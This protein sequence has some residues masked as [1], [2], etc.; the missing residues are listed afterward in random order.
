MK[1]ALFLFPLVFLL[2]FDSIQLGTDYYVTAANE[3]FEE[4]GEQEY[5]RFFLQTTEGTVGGIIRHGVRYYQI[6]IPDSMFFYDW[7][8]IPYKQESDLDYIFT[9]L[10]DPRYN[11]LDRTWHLF[12]RD[13]LSVANRSYVQD[14]AWDVG[15]VVAP[16]AAVGLVCKGGKYF[17][18]SRKGGKVFMGMV[19]SSSRVKRIV[20]SSWYSGG[21]VIDEAMELA[22]YHLYKHVYIPYNSGRLPQWM[23]QIIRNRSTDDV[24]E[25]YT[26]YFQNLITHQGTRVE[27]FTLDNGKQAFK[28]FWGRG[29]NRNS[30]GCTF[31]RK[32]NGDVQLVTAFFSKNPNNIPIL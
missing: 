2:S 23:N 5:D 20:T 8:D 3:V 25:W 10:A 14:A 24:F 4:Q 31:V 30:T 12:E 29:A 22:S 15:M 7:G 16:A 32:A 28:A 13:A 21:R 27:A 17:R 1:K 11:L 19:L 18:M 9:D 6:P 26:E